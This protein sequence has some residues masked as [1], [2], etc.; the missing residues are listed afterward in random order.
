MLLGVEAFRRNST[1]T[2][3]YRGEV[4]KVLVWLCTCV[5]CRVCMYRYV[6]VYNTNTHTHA[7][8][9]LYIYMYVHVCVCVCVCVCVY[10]QAAWTPVP[11][12]GIK[13]LHEP[14]E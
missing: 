11:T 10:D 3:G 1:G 2:R 5:M 6:H 12:T 4:L 9:H 8:T 13:W 14:R 7:H